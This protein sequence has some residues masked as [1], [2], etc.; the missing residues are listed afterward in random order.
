VVLNESGVMQRMV[1]DRT[2]LTWNNFWSGPR[3]QCDTY[4]LCGAFGVCNVGEAMVCDCFRGFMPGSPAEWLMRNATSGCTRSTPLQCAGGD[5]FYT[6]RGVKL[7][8]THGSTVDAG[9][10]LEECGRR[11]LS[12]CNCTAYA[13]SDIRGGGNGCIQWFGELMDTR[14]V[15]DGQDIFVRLA[16][17]DLGLGKYASLSTS[18]FTSVVLICSLRTRIIR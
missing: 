17:P 11:C 7:P 4:G 5:G 16:K 18:A 9:A 14:F 3:D 8:E 15:D 12:N 13:A 2:W 10:T 1:W 6:L